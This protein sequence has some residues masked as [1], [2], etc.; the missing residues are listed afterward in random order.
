M[1]K[2]YV[3]KQQIISYK[4]YKANNLFFI[5]LGQRRNAQPACTLE[6][7]KELLNKLENLVV[8][9][10]LNSLVAMQNG[11]NAL[12]VGQKQTGLARRRAASKQRQ[13]DYWAAFIKSHNIDITKYIEDYNKHKKYCPNRHL[14]LLYKITYTQVRGLNKFLGLSGG[15][16]GH[17]NGKVTIEETNS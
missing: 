8:A 16:S 13:Q 3:Y 11:L 5:C 2:G 4:V 17:L 7:C 12:T 15:G 6:Q 14:E 1:P 10:K 9:K